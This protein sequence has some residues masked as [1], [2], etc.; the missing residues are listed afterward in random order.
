VG[1]LVTAQPVGVELDVTKI[2]MNVQLILQHAKTMAPAETPKEA[3]LALAQRTGKDNF[4]KLMLTSAL[5]RPALEP[6]YVTM[7]VN[8]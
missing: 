2:L 6:N 8:V 7:M 3:S 1:S 4:V 5:T